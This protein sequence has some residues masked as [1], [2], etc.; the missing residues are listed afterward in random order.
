LAATALT[1]PAVYPTIASAENARRNSETVALLLFTG[2]G[3]KIGY[4]PLKHQFKNLFSHKNIG[5]SIVVLSQKYG[6]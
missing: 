5:H 6:T 3:H 4:A 1:S 2:R